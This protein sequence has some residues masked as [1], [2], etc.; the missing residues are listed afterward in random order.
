VLPPRGAEAPGEVAGGAARSI[1]PVL[2]LAALVAALFAPVLFGRAILFERDVHT[3]YFE[4]AETF[5][6]AIAEGSPPLW[7]PYS[8]F[9]A[10]LLADPSY[11]A[12]YPVTWLNLVFLPPA[13]YGV[14]A[15]FHCFLAGLG[16]YLLARRL[17]SSALAAFAG[18]AAA[19]S[20][21]PFL[22]S[23][24]LWH[25]FAGASW[26]PLF[27]VA[28]D[29][30]LASPSFGRALLLGA[31]AAAQVLAGSGDM[32]L[33][34]AF[35]ALSYVLLARPGRPGGRQV[36][37]LAVALLFALGLSAVQWIPTLG[38][39]TAGTR[40]RLP[41]SANAYWS[42]HPASLADLVFP[43][44]VARFPLS[45]AVRADL[46][47]GREPLLGSLYLG[48]LAL[49]VGACA[50]LGRATAWALGCCAFLVAASLGRHAFLFPWL[51]RIP[52]VAIFRY[53]AKC[54]VPA[55]LL[56][57]LLVAAGVEAWG[58]PWDG[59]GRR[60]GRVL[61]I[62]AAAFGLVSLSAALYL[63]A[64]LPPSL[65]SALPAGYALA[66][67]TRVLLR[68]ALVAALGAALLF[69]RSRS[70]EPRGYLVA[71]A[72]SL[73]LGDLLLVG[74]GINPVAPRELAAGPP[75]A[76]RFLKPGSRVYVVQDSPA[77]LN[78]QFV[79]GPSG[80]P[81]EAA[82][83]LGIDSLLSPPVGGRFGFFGGFDPDFTGLA[84]RAITEVSGIIYYARGLPL[85]ARIL[86]AGSVDA[87]IALHEAPL[88]GLEPVGEARSVFSEPVRVFHVPN[89]LPRAYV[90]G[91]A[92]RA[93]PR[94]LID[95]LVDPGFDLLREVVSPSFERPV[96]EGFSGSARILARRTDALAIEVEAS[97]PAF[98]V[99]TEAFDPGWR[100]EEDGAPRPLFPANGA[101]RGVE[102]GAGRHRVEMRYR[103]Q[104]A[105]LGAFVS[106]AAVLVACAAWEALRRRGAG[107]E[108]EI[109]RLMG[110]E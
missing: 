1:L 40:L 46:F 60:R 88:L 9:G 65:G 106:G 66:A 22:S 85:A 47:E 75:E 90:V 52:G 99:V 92:R 68:S 20:S 109:V 15:A 27:L 64:H 110:R 18:G 58:R 81:R 7:D 79:R 32:C 48:V 86:A 87:V 3:M 76:T 93:T 89:T 103:P 108:S 97:A 44:L 69:L 36:G 38:I 83:A 95:A 8:G 77:W 35:L 61:A 91:G 24:N 82:W 16:I 5:A 4:R 43:S 50:R 70:R 72:V 94:G 96:P 84:P 71:A 56:F 102:V 11:E 49:L 30:T 78:E 53:P 67:S 34:T 55:A 12:A 63:P 39:V 29:G 14:F 62:L 17:G 105:T 80:W 41:A 19:A 98:L 59:D 74:R 2:G 42:I 28:L 45:P 31:V 26:I 107:K 10:P 73:L 101:F 57:G 13:Y 54:L 6:R 37:M 23:V 25:H 33:V 51:V 104:S 100:A 21:G